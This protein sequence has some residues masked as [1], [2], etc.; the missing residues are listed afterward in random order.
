MLYSLLTIRL[1][2][3]LLAANSNAGFVQ[4]IRTGDEPVLRDVP[5]DR[6]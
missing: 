2:L 5:R 1:T 3:A 6:R 4:L